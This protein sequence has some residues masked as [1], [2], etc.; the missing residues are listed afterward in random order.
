M[1]S[2]MLK[3]QTQL[4]LAVAGKKTLAQQALMFN[5]LFSSLHFTVPSTLF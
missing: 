2:W 5:F 4:S 3:A 1:H